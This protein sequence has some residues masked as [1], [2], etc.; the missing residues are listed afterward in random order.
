MRKHACCPQIYSTKHIQYVHRVCDN[1]EGADDCTTEFKL[2]VGRALQK[3][4]PG[5]KIHWSDQMMRS[6][7][8][9]REDT[10]KAA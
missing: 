5:M 7:F 3:S 4:G 6:G 8:D 2:P 1:G 10:T 9:E